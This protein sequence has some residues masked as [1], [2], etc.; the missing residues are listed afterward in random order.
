MVG[1]AGGATYA[2]R[3]PVTTLTPTLIVL[4]PISPA[5]VRSRNVITG[6]SN[7]SPTP[8]RESVP[9]VIE[10]VAPAATP[11]SPPV[12]LLRSPMLAVRAASTA[13]CVT[14]GTGTVRGANVP[15]P[16]PTSG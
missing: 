11:R 13:N 4:A 10:L 2:E 7:T 12:T 5:L 16:L 15:L 1:A 9:V 14:F 3:G 8:T 6:A